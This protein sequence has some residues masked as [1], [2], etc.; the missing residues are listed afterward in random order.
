MTVAELIK[1]VES[2]KV[3]GDS[4]RAVADLTDDNRLAT[5]GSAFVAVRGANADGHSFIQDA[6]KRGATTILCETPPKSYEE[7]TPNVTVVTVPDT[8]A[9]LA[10]LASNFYGN[11]CDALTMVGVMGTNGKTSTAFLMQHILD[12]AGK[13]CARFGTAGHQIGDAEIVAKTTTP[14]ALELNQLLRQSLDKGLSAASMEA[15][16]HGLMTHRLD[17]ISFDGV[18]WTN[19]TQDHLD[20]HETMDA[21][22]D[23]K[24]R[25]FAHVKD[26]GSVALN[27]DDEWFADFHAAAVAAPNVG[28][29]LSYGLSDDADVRAEGVAT[30]P[31]E[32]SFTLVYNGTRTPIRLNLL[33]DYNVENALAALSVGIGLG[34][35]RDVLK[36]GVESLVNVPGRFET[37]NAGQNFGVVVDYAHTPDALERLL[38]AARRLNPSRV[39]VVF[40][41]G[42]NRDRTKRPKMGRIAAELGDVV[43][44]TSDNP[45]LEDPDAILREVVAGIPDGAPY[46]SITDRERAIARAIEIAEEGDLVLIAGKGHED[47]QD[48]G[49]KKIHFDDR[50]VARKYL[51][52]RH[53]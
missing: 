51:T 3:L 32:T 6:I 24:L 26:G 4:A 18:A 11:P 27:R 50:E 48:A 53:P 34:L 41:C 29:V 23:A 10:E 44:A 33:G 42:G 17:G 47:Y 20:F 16:S 25:L 8:R 37:A 21:Y 5:P 40:G 52:Q 39:I 43:I 38:G 49:G 9:A 22:R 7:L 46:E 35:S 45:R 1:G 15:S 36:R 31:T 14:S 28:K 30:T 13:P 2:A 12:A 19:L